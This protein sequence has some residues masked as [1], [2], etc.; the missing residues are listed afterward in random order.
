MMHPL[1]GLIDPAEFSRAGSD[2]VDCAVCGRGCASRG[3]AFRSRDGLTTICGQCL[4]REM[5][6]ESR[7][8]G[9]A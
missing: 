2:H 9:V 3:G 8:A 7:R 6:R 1:P 4:D 5:A